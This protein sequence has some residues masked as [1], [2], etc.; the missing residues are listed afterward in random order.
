MGLAAR[1]AEFARH[2][3]T[4]ILWSSQVEKQNRE[5]TQTGKLDGRTAWGVFDYERPASGCRFAPR[6]PV[7]AQRG[8]PAECTDPAKVVLEGVVAAGRINLKFNRESGG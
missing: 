6:C 4:Y 8:R 3:Y 1:I 2:P 5:A 7:Y